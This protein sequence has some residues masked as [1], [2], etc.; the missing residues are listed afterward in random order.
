MLYGVSCPR[1]PFCTVF[2]LSVPQR[3]VCLST[4]S[5]TC[6]LDSVQLYPGTRVPGYVPEL[7]NGGILVFPTTFCVCAYPGY[8][9]RGAPSNPSLGVHGTV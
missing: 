1:I 5:G 4:E 3:G 9:D 6:W 7:G 8:E 2:Q